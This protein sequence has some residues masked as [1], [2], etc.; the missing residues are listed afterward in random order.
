[1]TTIVR[2]PYDP[3]LQAALELMPAM[4]AIT[5]E[6]LPAAR[7]S[8]VAPPIES[9]IADRP[10]TYTDYVV[11]GYDGGEIVVSVLKRADH[12]RADGA[13]VFFIHGGG[14]IVGDRWIGAE[15][16]VN[17]VEKYDVVA[18]T[19]EYRL[20]PEFPDPVPVEDCYAGLTWFAEHSDALGFRSSRILITGG[21]A[22]GGL[23]AGVGL[24]ARDRSGPHLAAQ[25]LDCPMLDDRDETLSTRQFSGIGIWDRE[26]N[27]FG[28]SSLLGDR[29]ATDAVS[30]Y[31]APA[32]A[33]DLGGLPPTFLD[34]GSAEV[35]R[36]ETIAYA[37]KIWAAGGQAELHVWA[38]G[39]HGYEVVTTAAV[40]R[41]TLETREAWVSRYLAE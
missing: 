5:T 13:A 27:V 36:D 12:T 6:M 8:L 21:S 14:M 2:P 28:W 15:A 18:A 33:T 31:A 9:V 30:I 11:P 20:A 16:L 7:A 29:V 4:P 1:M 25:V 38:G 17:W 24:L 3:E 10:I 41:T 39:F 40:S 34:V 23:A 26:A 22:G 35:F 32:R 19:V 37:Q